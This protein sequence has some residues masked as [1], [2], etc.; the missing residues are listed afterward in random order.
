MTTIVQ[1]K[2]DPTV[3]LCRIRKG[4]PVVWSEGMTVEV[5]AVNEETCSLHHVLCYHTQTVQNIAQFT[6]KREDEREIRFNL[7]YLSAA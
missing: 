3:S 6:E 1:L 5:T 2:S 7:G 4:S